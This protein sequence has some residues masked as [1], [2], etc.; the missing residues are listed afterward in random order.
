MLFIDSDD[1]C[2]GNELI[3]SPETLAKELYEL[4]NQRRGQYAGEDFCGGVRP[5]FFR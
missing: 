3:D 2:W 1:N 4:K 5:V